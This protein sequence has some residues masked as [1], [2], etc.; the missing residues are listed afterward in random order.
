MATLISKN[1]SSAYSDR[2]GLY[3]LT[4]NA[5][6]SRNG[7]SRHL[8]VNGTVYLNREAENSPVEVARFSRTDAGELYITVAVSTSSGEFDYAAL[9]EIVKRYV[10]EIEED[11]AANEQ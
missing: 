9:E 5:G 6:I 2:L 3:D 10:S 1:I 11:A 8:S 7:D 4:A